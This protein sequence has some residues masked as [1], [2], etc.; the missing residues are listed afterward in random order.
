MLNNKV[1]DVIVLEHEAK[2]TEINYNLAPFATTYWTENSIT[3]T[4]IPWLPY[5]S[6]CTYQK[7]YI[8]LN[9][10]LKPDECLA[11]NQEIV[12][13]SKKRIDFDCIVE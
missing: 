10:I 4:M 5:F 7:K 13:C 2:L 3:A 9:D 8:L 11:D 6:Q 1:S 12:K